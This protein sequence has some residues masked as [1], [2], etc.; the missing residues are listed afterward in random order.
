MFI[1][2]AGEVIRLVLAEVL[3]LQF[4]FEE[5]APHYDLAL[6]KARE[7]YGANSYLLVFPLNQSAAMLHELGKSDRAIEQRQEAL[8]IVEALDLPRPIRLGQV[9]HDLAV[10][11]LADLRFE[12]AV[13]T[14]QRAIEAR[15]LPL[16]LECSDRDPTGMK[17]L[18]RESSPERREARQEPRRR[19]LPSLW[20]SMR[21]R[22]PERA[23][24]IRLP[25]ENPISG[26]Y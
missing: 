10:E 8:R 22:P 9:L 14:A 1:Y 5:A 4:R 26:H 2:G 13:T 3:R 23:G 20:S 6:E 11:Y 7:A 24:T 17:P 15:D 19:T 21:V 18:A 25:E 12:S 16:T